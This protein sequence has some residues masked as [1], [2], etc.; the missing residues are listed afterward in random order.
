VTKRANII[1]GLH[2]S[3]QKTLFIE[4][5]F[6]KRK[7]K[8]RGNPSS[9]G[10]DSNDSNDMYAA[11]L[12]NPEFANILM[13]LL[14]QKGLD[15]GA[16]ETSTQLVELLKSNPE[17][18]RGFLAAAP[19]PEEVHDQFSSATIEPQ[20]SS[21]QLP[22]MEGF[23]ASLELPSQ[24]LHSEHTSAT[25]HHDPVVAESPTLLHAVPTTAPIPRVLKMEDTAPSFANPIPSASVPQPNPSLLAPIQ[26][27]HGVA[28][29]HVQTRP[30][31]E[32]I[33]AL[34]FPPMVGTPQ[35]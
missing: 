13:T 5:E 1:F 14:A 34:G 10:A 9:P 33:R 26:L 28:S 32:R 29:S 12:N 16:T 31:Q 23:E 27:P 18:L 20:H 4:N 3:P 22:L 8:R 11:I 35:R 15:A 25:L 30:S 21:D 7:S 24:L 2:P 17:F 6:K 19:K